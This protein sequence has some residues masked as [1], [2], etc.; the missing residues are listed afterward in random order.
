[1]SR[2]VRKQLYLDSAL[3]TRLAGVA[4]REGVSQAEV[5]RAALEAY[6]ATT[7][8]TTPDVEWLKSHWA[9]TD[10]LGVG[11]AGWAYDRDELHER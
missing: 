5:V 6:F 2:M 1:M 4:R 10:R 3:D 11:S 9:E 8:S 7:G